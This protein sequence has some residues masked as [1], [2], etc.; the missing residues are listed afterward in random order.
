M[1]YTHLSSLRTNGSRAS[2][3]PVGWPTIRACHFEGF[4]GLGFRVRIL[5][6]L[7]NMKPQKSEVCS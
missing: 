5:F 4:E 2:R 7:L 6:M 1:P 3:R